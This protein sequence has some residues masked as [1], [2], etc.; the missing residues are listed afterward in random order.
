[1]REKHL[2]LI[3]SFDTTTVA[4][5]V[6]ALCRQE[7][8]PGRIIPLPKE[9]SAGCGLSWRTEISQRPVMEALFQ[10][11]NIVPGGMHEI[12]L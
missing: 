12:L 3:I 9:V 2:W 4:M 5:A 11:E 7:G 8:I 6:D 10:R 1:M